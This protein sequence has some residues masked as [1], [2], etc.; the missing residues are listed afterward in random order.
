MISFK[1][2][3]D[4]YLEFNVK[5]NKAP[6]IISSVSGELYRDGEYLRTFVAR[7]EKSRV[8]GLIVGGTFST[9]GEYVAKFRVGLDS[10]GVKEHA[11]P[12]RI[13]KSVLGKKRAK[14]IDRVMA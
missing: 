4:V 1:L 14:T 5:I 12:F 2:G 3:N 13:T 9:T 7:N 6:A 11:V 10:M 8:S